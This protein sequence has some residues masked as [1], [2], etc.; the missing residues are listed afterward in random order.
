MARRGVKKRDYEKLDDSTVSRVISLLG[1]KNKPIT[2][3]E[4][5]KILNINYNT[6]RL[7]KIIQEYND[8]IEYAK[9]RRAQNKGKPLSDYEIKDVVISYL[10]GEA[11]SN[12]ANRLFRSLSSIQ[13]VLRDNKVA[14]RKTKSSYA[15]PELI[16]EENASEEFNPGELVWSAKY[17]C[18]AE[19]IKLRQ[20][21]PEHGNV[22]QL[23]VYG[24]T[25]E[26]ANQP[27][28]ELG[29]MEI[30]KTLGISRTDVQITDRLDIMEKIL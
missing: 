21:S 24:K 9:R 7:A 2:K 13:K 6:S 11:V 12:I 16:P 25:M 27:A 14:V 3:T 28:Y 1:D 4:A 23:W 17:N 26:F 15:N 18:V 30:L 10:K 19:V 5:C 29:K 22:Y 20:V 8:K